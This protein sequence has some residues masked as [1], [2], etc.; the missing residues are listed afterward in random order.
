MIFIKLF[1]HLKV[2]FLPFDQTTCSTATKTI[3]KAFRPRFWLSHYTKSQCEGLFPLR[4]R[5]VAHPVRL[6][7]FGWACGMQS[8]ARS[9]V[10]RLDKAENF[11]L[12][13]FE[14]LCDVTCAVWQFFSKLTGLPFRWSN[15]IKP[16]GYFRN[17]GEM[18]WMKWMRLSDWCTA[19]WFQSC[20]VLLIVELRISGSN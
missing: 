2:F 7:P 17:F 10:H 16:W 9:T 6:S 14:V 4:V 3:W 13:Y 1:L 11:H 18:F 15:Q 8:A 5:N 20:L 19:T 12:N